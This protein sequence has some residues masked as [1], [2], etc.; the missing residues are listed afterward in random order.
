MNLH[1]DWNS[2]LITT[3]GTLLR[4]DAD[5]IVVSSSGPVH[6]P[7]KS[8]NFSATH[9]ILDIVIIGKLVTPVCLT[10]C[11]ALSSVHL[12]MLID[13]LRRSSILNTQASRIEGVTGPNSTRFLKLGS[14]PNLTSR[15]RWLLTRV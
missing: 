6:L 11:S 2:R 3:G 15:M 13:K 14:R 8:C 4:D 12:C 7:P 9:D 10:M 5:K 1:V